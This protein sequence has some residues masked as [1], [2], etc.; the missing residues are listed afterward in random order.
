VVNEQRTGDSF[1][2]PLPKR[3]AGQDIPKMKV[4]GRCLPRPVALG[5]ARL[6]TPT[7]SCLSVPQSFFGPSGDL[8][9]V[10]REDPAIGSGAAPGSAGTLPGEPRSPIPVGPARDPRS[11][12][13]PDGRVTAA[14]G[15]LATRDCSRACLIGR[16]G[17]GRRGHLHGSSEVL[18]RLRSR[19]RGRHGGH[20]VRAEAD[21]VVRRACTRR[22]GQARDCGLTGAMDDRIAN[23]DDD[24]A[25]ASMRSRALLVAATL[26]P[27]NHF[28]VRR[29]GASTVH[30][31]VNVASGPSCQ[32]RRRRTPGGQQG[33]PNAL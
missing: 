24:S 3:C 25:P 26:S 15:A 12:A 14:Y 28:S 16:V 9:L 22:P 1:R 30:S 17:A 7:Q 20:L 23:I 11:W 29:T 13:M 32:R 10:G 5:S 18:R 19:V 6:S 2:N 4:A 27:R 21:G 33:D 8:Q 31:H